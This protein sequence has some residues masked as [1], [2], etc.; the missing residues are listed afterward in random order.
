TYGSAP[1]NRVSCPV[2][3]VTVAADGLSVRLATVCLREGYIHE[4]KA[5]GVHAASDGATLLHPTAYYTLN[6]LPDG[7]RIIPIEPNEA[8]LCV[9]PVPPEANA[10]TAK[11]PARAPD[12]WSDKEGDQTIL[13]STQ[14]GLKF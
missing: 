8:E 11:H 14:P 9:A 3:K 5:A 4:I 12:D 10:I 2:R 6:R 13:I 7:D 1:I